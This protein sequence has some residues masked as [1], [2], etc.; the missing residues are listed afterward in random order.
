MSSKVRA[1]CRPRSTCS[2]GERAARVSVVVMGIRRVKTRKADERRPR[3][4]RTGCVTWRSG[5]ASQA[6][7]VALLVLLAAAARAVVVATDLGDVAAHRAL[8]VVAADACRLA[9]RWPWPS[10]H[11]RCRWPFRPR[12]AQADSPAAAS[13]ARRS[14]ARRGLLHDRGSRRRAGQWTARRRRPR[15]R[16]SAGHRAGGSD[17]PNIGRRRH[18]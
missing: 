12:A 17:R 10:A 14:P 16:S 13:A 4:V 11:R 9:A 18:R 3:G 8:R 1:V 5:P 7:P 15:S 6:R 2:A